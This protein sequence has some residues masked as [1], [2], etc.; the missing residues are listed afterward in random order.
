MA[1]STTR[2]RRAT[3]SLASSV[4]IS[5][6]LER[7]RTVSRNRRLNVRYPESKSVVPRPIKIRKIA[8]ID[9]FPSAS[10]Q[11]HRAGS[12][13]RPAH[14]HGHVSGI[15]QNRP[16]Q[17]RSSF[18]RIGAVSVSQDDNVKLFAA[19]ANA[20]RTACPLPCSGTSITRIPKPACD[21]ARAIG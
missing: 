16:D 19:Q 15:D 18:S 6:P 17:E 14:S 11:A 7:S 13:R 21:L 10:S 8:R 9:R 12:R 3:A 5:K 20:A 4:S 1:T 2:S